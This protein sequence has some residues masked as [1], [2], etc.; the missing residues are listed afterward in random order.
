MKRSTAVKAL[1]GMA[2]DASVRRAAPLL[3]E[4]KR[5]RLGITIDLGDLHGDAHGEEHGEA[6]DDEPEI[7][8]DDQRAKRRN[9]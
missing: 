9:R 4:E 2:K 6:L 7:P 3:D 1:R 8:A 5:R